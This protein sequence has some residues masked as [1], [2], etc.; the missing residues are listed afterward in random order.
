MWY[1]YIL[2]SK[3]DG[4][5]YIGLTND[6]RRRLGLHNNGKVHSTRLRKPFSVIYYEAHHN[7]YDAAK[8]EQFLKTGWGKGWIKRTLANYF[9]S[10]KLGG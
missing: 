9:L 3:K 6:L 4:C 7:K 8:R 5:L 1:A 10:K 2:Q